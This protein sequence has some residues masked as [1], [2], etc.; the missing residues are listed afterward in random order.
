MDNAIALREREPDAVVLDPYESTATGTQVYVASHRALADPGR[1]DII[2]RYLR[3]IRAAMQMVIEDNSLD[4][5]LDMLGARYDIPILADR[6]L[7]KQT[8]RDYIASW[9]ANGALLT[10]SA[11][12][13]NRIYDETV[14]V[15]LVPAGLDAAAWY[16]N[17][18]LGPV[19]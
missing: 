18:L 3:A 16:T 7:A 8:L 4:R 13:W 11:E 12:R 19:P 1:R 9:Q 14:G 10:T 2:A 17:D 6:E 15:G 5:T